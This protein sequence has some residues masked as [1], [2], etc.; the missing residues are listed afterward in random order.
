MEWKSNTSRGILQ[1]SVDG[2][3]LG[4]TLDQYANPT[5]Y[6]TTTFGTVSFG[7]TG[8]HTIMLTVTGKNPSSSNYQL[9]ADKFVFV[10]LSSGGQAIAP[11][12]TPAGGTYTSAQNVTISTATGG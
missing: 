10:G 9:S 5:V 12:F 6:P 11:S 7:S 1:L 2:T 8:K 3:N 4:G